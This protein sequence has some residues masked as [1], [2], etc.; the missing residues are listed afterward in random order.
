MGKT[1]A[2]ENRLKA[3]KAGMSHQDVLDEKK[4]E[5]SKLK[6]LASANQ[7]FGQVKG[8]AMNTK[9]AKE[10]QR[11]KDL[12]DP[13]TKIG[14]EHLRAQKKAAKEAQEFLLRTKGIDIK[15]PEVAEGVDKKTVLCEFFKHGCCAKTGD[16][17]AF[18]HDLAINEKIAKRSLFE[19]VDSIDDWDQK[20]LEAVIQKKH[21]QEVNSSNETQIICK[22]FLDAVEKKLYGWFWQCADGKDCKYKH[23]LPPG[24]VFA[25]DIRAAEL[26][27]MKNRKTDQDVLREKLNELKVK[28]GTGTP[29]TLEN[30]LAW[31]EKKVAAR[32]ATDEKELRERHK[33]KLFTGKELVEEITNDMDDKTEGEDEITRLLAE[34]AKANQES[35]DA[36]RKEAEENLARAKELGD[37]YNEDMLPDDDRGMMDDLE[38][39][40]VV[41]EGWS[42][43]AIAPNVVAGTRE[44]KEIMS[45]LE[46]PEQ[47]GMTEKQKKILEEKKKLEEEGIAIAQ[48]T[49]KPRDPDDI[50]KPQTEIP[51]EF[52]D[53]DELD[54]KALG[55]AIAKKRAAEEAEASALI[56]QV[57]EEKARKEA[58]KAEKK[59]AREAERAKKK[60]SKKGIKGEDEEEEI[61]SLEQAIGKAEIS[62][63]S[64]A[65]LKRTVTGVLSSQIAARDIKIT[66]FSMTMNGRVLID[67]C[68]IELTIGRRYGLIGQN[69]SGKTNFLE[70]LAMREVPIPD[71]VD[72]YHLKT[73]A[74]PSDR[75]AIQC[76]IDELVEEMERLNKFEQHLLENFGPDDERLM[77]LYDR[78]EEIDPSTFEARASELLH[79]LGFSAE[80][81]DRPTKDMSGGWRMR[82]ALAKALFATPTIL[83]LDEPTNH[84][85]LEACVWLENHLALY[86]KCLVVVSHSQD[87]LNGVCSHMI[88][89][90]D[91]KLKYYSGNYDTY[92]RTVEEDNI[93]QQ[94]KYE[95]E[96]SDINHLKEFIRSCGTYA[97]ARKQAESKQKII[98]KMIAAGLTPPVHKERTFT[99]NFPDCDKV[100][101]PVLPFDQVSFAYNGKEENYLYD[102]LDL[103][104]DCDSRVAL[105]GPNG[106]GK[107]TL[108]KLMTGE[109]TPTKG[110]VSRHSALN[111]GKYHQH[112]V[113]VLD[114]SK[115]VLQFFMDTY[116]NVHGKFKRDIDEW[117][118]F[119]GK[120]GIAGKQQT[121]LI[122]ELSE[123]QQSRLVFAMICMG[124]PNL[125]LL[126]EPTNHLDLEAIDALAEAIKVYNGGV[127][128]VSHDFRLIDQVARDIWVCEDKTVRRWDKDIREYKKHLSKKAER[129]AKERKLAKK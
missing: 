107:S 70:C 88:W 124:K 1:P 65:G 32:K 44:A 98:D 69:G 3:K 68:D 11:L 64:K 128:L 127:I 62:G 121:T 114:R 12:N 71:H 78:L 13:T 58:A 102:K 15:Q 46:V 34:R 103:G 86:K 67:E 36:A 89:L 80:M 48:D 75:S 6:K 4:K 52:K 7:S 63:I 125:L 113:E 123:G 118:A 26:E 82:V 100:P 91:G 84:L 106:A 83:L 77:S 108:L 53:M 45:A 19:N 126:D 120:Y 37:L 31:K 39:D 55:E 43:D 115:T 22:H 49:K 33:K 17:C 95:K 18:S 8:A 41:P 72:I 93:V 57:A 66:N 23:K 90:T 99:F 81:I 105:V 21:G 35:E 92:C 112:S 73:E 111:I 59:A 5:D 101:P 85:D 9:H 76:V 29:V 20:K 56:L 74:E 61:T 28:G 97:N 109:L 24:Y 79:S 14:R 10:M 50:Y 122:G 110:S 25:A 54:P 42:E 87:F 104:V 96:Q 60:K 16:K 94:R 119:L 117:R 30:Y 51:D 116:P 129:E 38:E 40:L 2:Q 27:A 47:K